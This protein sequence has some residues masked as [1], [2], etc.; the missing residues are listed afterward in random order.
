MPSRTPPSP[1]RPLALDRRSDEERGRERRRPDRAPRSGGPDRRDGDH[2][3]GRKHRRHARV[4][5]GDRPALHARGGAPAPDAR[6]RP[7][8]PR[9]SGRPGTARGEGSVGLRDGRR[10]AAPTRADRVAARAGRV[11]RPRPR[12]REPLLR[13][14]LDRLRLGARDGLSLHHG[15][16]AAA[17]SAAPSQRHGSHERLLPGAPR[18]DRRR[19]A[20]ATR[21]Q[22]P[23]RAVDP[24]SWAPVRR[25]VVRVRRTARRSQQGDDPRGGA[26]P[27]AARAP[28]P[29]PLR[30]RR[31][32]GSGGEH[33]PACGADRRRGPV[34]RR[35]GGHRDPGLDV[36]ELLLH[37]A[38]GV[39]RSRPQARHGPPH[40]ALLPHEQR[41]ARGERTAARAAHV[42]ARHSLPGLERPVVGGPHARALRARRHLDLGEGAAERRRAALLQ[43]RHP[44]DRHRE[45]GRPPARAGALPHRRA[46]R[47]GRH[48]GAGGEGEP[49]RRT[50]P[51][52]T[53]RDP[54]A[55]GSVS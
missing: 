39:R 29:R 14:R 2:L 38:L 43:L 30:D 53:A 35:V 47:R 51:S 46:D 50:P 42:R 44:R 33:P 28:A 54:V 26:L 11:L 25:G 17:V 13:G 18:R 16:G 45:V 34:L 37:R 23:A 9:G 32:L 3:R 8:R 12:R 19:R 6:T 31:R 21:V 1:A 27:V 4:H 7:Q 10:P 5:R 15:G 40:G 55:W 49:E 41:G 20:A 22:D 52:T 24:H 48:P 36:V